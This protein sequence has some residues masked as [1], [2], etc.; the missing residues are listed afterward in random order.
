MRSLDN[1]PLLATPQPS[2]KQEKKELPILDLHSDPDFHLLPE[3]KQ[4]HLIKQK[5]KLHKLQLKE[6]KK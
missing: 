2:L 4:Y 5:V 1:I 6:L 3:T